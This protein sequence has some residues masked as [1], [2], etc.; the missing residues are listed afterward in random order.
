MPNF[1]PLELSCNPFAPER[2]VLKDLVG[3]PVKGKIGLNDLQGK[4]VA[5]GTFLDNMKKPELLNHTVVVVGPHMGGRTSFCGLV[6]ER[7]W[8]RFKDLDVGINPADIFRFESHPQQGLQ[9]DKGPNENLRDLFRHLLT[10]MKDDQRKRFAGVDFK[11]A[12]RELL[13]AKLLGDI[14][15][16]FLVHLEDPLR[17]LPAPK[18]LIFENLDSSELFNE[19]FRALSDIPSIKIITAYSNSPVHKHLTSALSSSH[20]ALV[21]ELESLDFEEVRALVKHTLENARK[22][23]AGELFPFNEK[24]ISGFFELPNAPLQPFGRITRACFRSIE[25]MAEE[26]E[27]APH[28]ARKPPIDYDYMRDTLTR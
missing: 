10:A 21:T 18:V 14:S 5:Y 11:D 23:H 15:A 19:L 16:A 22:D 1:I 6:L 26:I 8:Q 20:Q 17:D 9:D 27:S 2:I 13:H 12:K 24:A 4:L 28:A 3:I 25:R 7:L